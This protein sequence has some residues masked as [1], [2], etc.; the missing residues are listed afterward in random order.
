MGS[1][2]RFV[3]SLPMNCA[4]TAGT[5]WFERTLDDSA[6]RR[7]VNAQAGRR[8]TYKFR[9]VENFVKFAVDGSKS[10]VRF[11]KLYQVIVLAVN[12]YV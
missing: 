2:A 11:D 6:N 1:L 9:R 4:I 7:I 5:Q 8:P 12:F 3:I 10:F